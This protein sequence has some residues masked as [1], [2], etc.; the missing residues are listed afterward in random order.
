MY[1]TEVVPLVTNN[2]T[3]LFSIYIAKKN[4]P[5]VALSS[6]FNSYLINWTGVFGGFST[7]NSLSDN[8]SL[9]AESKT[10]Q[11]VIAS[12]SNVSP[13]NNEIG[14]GIASETINGVSISSSVKFFARSI[15]VKFVVTRMKPKT[16]IYPFIDG[17]DMSRWVIPDSSFSG[18][19]GSSLSAFGSTIVTDESGNAS[20]ILLIPAG[21]PPIEGTFWTGRIVDV[22]YDKEQKEYI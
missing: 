16:R 4:D 15:P 17:R 22:E 1:D 18:V 14:K 10:T 20:G 21:Y 8:T 2:N 19:V 6:I 13:N 7:I 9:Q 3:N 11:S 12:S 5:K